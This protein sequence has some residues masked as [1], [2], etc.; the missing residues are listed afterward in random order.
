ML[1][2]VD[3]SKAF[4]PIPGG[5]IDDINSIR[6]FKFHP[7]LAMRLANLDESGAISGTVTD[8]GQMPVANAMVTA[9]LGDDEVASSATDM[10]GNYTIVGL[11]PDTYSMVMTA[12]GFMEGGVE[13]VI[14]EAGVTTEGVNVV[15]EPEDE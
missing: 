5:R 11:S 14:V 10:D 1:L 7:S 2:D 15:L 8:G 6:E 3:L 4:T 12:D 9:L 13:D